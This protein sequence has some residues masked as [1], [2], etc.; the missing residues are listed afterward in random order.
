VGSKKIFGVNSQDLA[1]NSL[2]INNCWVAFREGRDQSL[3][4]KLQVMMGN[5][6]ILP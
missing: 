5:S 1:F 2:L 4:S 6:G 3:R